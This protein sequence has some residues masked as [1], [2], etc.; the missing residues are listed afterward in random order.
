M[1]NIVWKQITRNHWTA[2]LP[3]GV[4]LGVVRN[5]S[6]KAQR[7]DK[8]FKIEVFGNIWAQ[9]HREG[10]EILEQAQLAAEDIAKKI[11]LDLAAWAA[12]PTFAPFKA[13][14]KMKRRSA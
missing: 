11:V 3:G 13:P 4:S 5:R 9:Q 8:P 14:A 12:I 1:T 10:Y 7:D 6:W 2:N